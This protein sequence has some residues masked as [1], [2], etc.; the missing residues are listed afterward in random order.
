LL[1]FIKQLLRVVTV[2]GSCS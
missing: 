2:S 1:K